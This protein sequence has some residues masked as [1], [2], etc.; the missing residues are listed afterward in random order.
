MPTPRT[1]TV[2][3][4]GFVAEVTRRR[5]SRVSFRA[6]PDGRVTVSAP[7]RCTKRE[8][9]R[10]VHEHEDAIRA[11]R[12]RVAPNDDERR[13]REQMTRLGPG[14]FVWFWGRRLAV[15]HHVSS[16]RTVTARVAGDFL[17]LE[18]PVELLAECAKRRTA[19]EALLRQELRAA[20][21]DVRAQAETAVG[22][23]S[24]AW[25]VRRMH[26]RWGSCRPESGRISLSLD[27][28]THAPHFLQLVAVHEVAHC[29]AGNHGAEFRA[30]MDRARPGWG[31]EQAEL[32]AEGVRLPR[33]AP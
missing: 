3:C 28:A 7:L 16:A 13:S 18:G 30:V 27:L 9:E 33:E 2:P 29:V 4:E 14:D 31:E 17:A 21:P 23:E 15:E 5:T 8:V 22:A 20:L 10:L 1:F 24:S 25:S 26:S 6:W 12:E 11:L 19:Y 32:D